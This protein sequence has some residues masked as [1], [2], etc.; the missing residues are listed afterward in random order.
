V[1]ATQQS[2]AIQIANQLISLSQTLMSIYQGM[3]VLDAAWSD[4]GTATVIAALGTVA[5]NADG[6]L[7]AADGAPNVAHPINPALFPVLTRALSS[8]QIT[9]LK[10]ILDAVVTL[11]NGSAVSAQTGARGILNAAVGG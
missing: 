7:G 9:Q 4:D 3:V 6:S 11:V 1:A 2:Q 5:L 8:N 10:T